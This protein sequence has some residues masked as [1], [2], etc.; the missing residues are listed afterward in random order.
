MKVIL[1]ERVQSLGNVGEIVNVSPGY[2]R[3]FLLPQKKAVFAD[4]GNTKQLEHYQKQLEKKIEEEKAAAEALKSKIEGLTLEMI[5]KVGGNGKLFG[6]VTNSDVAKELAKRDIEVERR[7]ITIDTPIKAI[8][9][10]EISAKLFS[11]V[12]A[13]F[14][15]KTVMDPKQA[16]ELKAKQEAAA[17]RAAKKKTEKAEAKEE[18][19][20]P[21]SAEE[22]SE[23]K[24]EE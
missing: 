7:L 23:E 21:E 20:Q 8:G 6:T 19:E 5:K 10:F 13:V 22:Q 11:G 3:N 17:K 24:S 15:V 4:E 1:T 16:E 14:K 18:A 12:E 9:T 2:A